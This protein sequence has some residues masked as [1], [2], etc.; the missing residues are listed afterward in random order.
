MLLCIDHVGL[1]ILPK[2]VT[3]LPSVSQESQREESAVSELQKKLEISV[4][5]SSSGLQI[6][7]ELED[8]EFLELAAGLIGDR[9]SNNG[10]VLHNHHV[11]YIL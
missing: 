1:Y 11:C 4:S 6:I 10:Q 8:R 3:E 5:R 2:Y 9:V 7:D